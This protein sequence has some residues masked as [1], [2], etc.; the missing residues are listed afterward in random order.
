M[1]DFLHLLV[2]TDFNPTLSYVLTDRQTDIKANT[3]PMIIVINILFFFSSFPHIIV[4]G[5]RVDDMRNEET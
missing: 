5:V 3:Q 2:G 1:V 4:S